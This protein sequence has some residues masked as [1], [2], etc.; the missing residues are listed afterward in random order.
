MSTN[1]DND[2]LDDNDDDDDQYDELG[3]FNGFYDVRT[4]FD[5]TFRNIC[6]MKR[7]FLNRYSLSST[8]GQRVFEHS[9]CNTEL[10]M[11]LNQPKGQ[12]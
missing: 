4:I 12:V 6:C 9:N 1:F 5:F 11:G 7:I 2:D 10:F 8:S 3:S